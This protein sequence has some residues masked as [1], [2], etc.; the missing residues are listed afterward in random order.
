MLHNRTSAVVVV[1]AVLSLLCVVPSFAAE[2]TV[3]PVCFQVTATSTGQVVSTLKF[4]ATLPLLDPPPPVPTWQLSGYELQSLY[5][6]GWVGVA[7]VKGDILLQITSSSTFANNLAAVRV[8]NATLPEG[9]LS[10]TGTCTDL[11]TP[12]SGCGTGTNVSYVFI[13]C[14]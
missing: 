11:L 3:G 2:T 6:S 9:Q 13:N 1:L 10:G 12:S 5:T 14:P 7:I 4:T 8:F